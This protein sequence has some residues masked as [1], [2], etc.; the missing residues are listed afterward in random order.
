MMVHCRERN[1][2][3]SFKAGKPTVYRLTYRVAQCPS[4]GNVLAAEL[5]SVQAGD[6]LTVYKD[7]ITLN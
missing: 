3:H 1:L 4:L 2:E 6:P 7:N 5:Y